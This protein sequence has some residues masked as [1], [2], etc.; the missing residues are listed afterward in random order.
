MDSPS[1]QEKG[2]AELKWRHIIQRKPK[3]MGISLW[4]KRAFLSKIQFGCMRELVK[5]VLTSN[6]VRSIY[7]NL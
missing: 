4:Q 6:P 5:E 3:E 7:Q 1:C 2:G